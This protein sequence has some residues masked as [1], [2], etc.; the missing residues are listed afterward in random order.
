MSMP[1]LR[2]HIAGST[3]RNIDEIAPEE[4]MVAV[5]VCVQ[6]ALGIYHED[7]LRETLK[8]FGLMTT[9]DNSLSLRIIISHM[10][11]QNILKLENGKI[12][13]GDNF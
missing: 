11:S 1:P 7:L 3:L 8:L 2:I 5:K 12:S 6:H 4:I 9:R 10:V 13:K